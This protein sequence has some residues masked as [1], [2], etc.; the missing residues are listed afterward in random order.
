M[1]CLVLE[2]IAS[3]SPRTLEASFHHDRVLISSIPRKSQ[4]LLYFFV[5]HSNEAYQD[6]PGTCACGPHTCFFHA[7]AGAIGKP[8]DYAANLPK[9]QIVAVQSTVH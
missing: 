6:V 1:E 2:V 9:V 5:L 4:C 8:L 3:H 7:A